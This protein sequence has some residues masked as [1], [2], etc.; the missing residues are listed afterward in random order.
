MTGDIPCLDFRGG[1]VGGYHNKHPLFH[2]NRGGRVLK[3]TQ[4]PNLLPSKKQV[5]KNFH[6]QFYTFGI[7]IQI[8]SPK[9]KSKHKKVSTIT[10][11][12]YLCTV[13]K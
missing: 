7:V 11:F 6:L 9:S 8:I 4:L 5:L 13:I 1:G 10:S 3:N 2:K 12:L